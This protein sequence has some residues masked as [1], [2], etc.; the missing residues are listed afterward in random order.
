[1]N[2][3]AYQE[4]IAWNTAIYVRITDN[5]KKKGLYDSIE[6]Q[7]KIL[8][9]YALDKGLGNTRIFADEHKK[10][11][12]FDRPAFQLMMDEIKQGNINCVLVKDL[13]R[14]GREHIEGDYLLEVFFPENNIRLISK[15][16]RIDSYTDPKR[17]NSIEI[18]LINLFNEQYLRQVS[19][20]TKASLKMKRKEGKFVGSRVPY[21]YLR[22]PEDKNLLI[23]D[24]EVRPVVAD[25]FSM[26][27]NYMSYNAI[28]Q[29]LNADSVPTPA[30][31]HKTLL[32]KA[33]DPYSAW[34][35]NTVRNIITQPIYTGDMV[36]GRSVS[37]SHKVKKRVPLPKEKWTVVKNMH[38]AIIDKE[39]FQIA[40]SISAKK[41][42]PISNGKLSVQPSVLAGFLV[43]GD[44]DSI[45]QRTISTH[46]GVKYYHFVCGTYK[47]LGKDACSNHL[48][49]EEKVKEILLMTINA[50][51]DAIVDIEKKIRDNRQ[52]EISK[53][54]MKLK[55]ELYAAQTERRKAASLKSELYIDYKQE[56]IS[57]E[58]YKDM[59]QRF[60]EQQDTLDVQIE[61]LGNDIHDL[62]HNNV[63]Q[64]DAA[65]SLMK[66]SEVSEITRELL[67]D[68]I[69]RIVIDKNKNIKI[70]FKFQDELKRHMII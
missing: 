22:S 67:G 48:V 38:E 23:V 19:N 34:N 17:M 12:N 46:K 5:E 55:H 6:N 61:K 28:A 11:G 68:L 37:Y 66:Y 51:I 47:K 69:E 15:M 29:K 1:M 36:Q 43:C 33:I 40:Q 3:F 63:Y 58:D 65:R 30:Q 52:S 8:E 53:M 39:T 70:I 10:G 7:I 25:I 35:A 20:S 45:M 41:S 59:K 9:Q 18:P 62:E 16:E 50:L 60:D 44:C 2:S 57:L 64:L 31:R 26:Y 32:G 14:F 27:L 49:S 24:E 21:G 54:K 4:N 42:R 13:S 56:V